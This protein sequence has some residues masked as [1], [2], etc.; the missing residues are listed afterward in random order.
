[1]TREFFVTACRMEVAEFFKPS[2]DAIVKIVKGIGIAGDLDPNNTVAADI[3][4]GQP[5]SR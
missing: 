1:M 2:I 4:S 3:S 5:N